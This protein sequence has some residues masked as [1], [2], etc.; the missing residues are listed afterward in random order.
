M[1]IIYS[2][3]KRKYEYNVIYKISIGNYSYI[4]LTS[5]PLDIRI[6]E[7]IY[8]K[9]SSVKQYL[10][11]HNDIN[12]ISVKIL[13][14]LPSDKKLDKKETK[15]IA[16]Y[17]IKNGKNKSQETLLNKDYKGL[18]KLTIEELRELVRNC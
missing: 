9:N 14:S 2:N 3:S 15:K 17:I 13:A 5:R 6:H 1:N 10:T 12:T 8:N 4:G 18:D 7:H 16:S 11:Q